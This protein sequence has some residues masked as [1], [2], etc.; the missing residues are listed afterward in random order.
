MERVRAVPTRTLVLVPMHLLFEVSVIEQ[1][2]E[3]LEKEEAHIAPYK[4]G[5]VIVEAGLNPGSWSHGTRG[6]RHWR[7][8]A[9]LDWTRVFV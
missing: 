1:V 4:T 5:A 2:E 6:N 7:W 3:I 8:R 9:N